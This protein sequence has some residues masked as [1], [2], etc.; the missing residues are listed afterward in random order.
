M[1]LPPQA[2]FHFIVLRLVLLAI[3]LL[4]GISESYGSIIL[5]SEKGRLFIYWGWNR[6]WYSKSNIGFLGDDYNFNLKRV[7]AKDRQSPF[8]FN[9]YL[10]PA[11]I[12][13]PQ[14]NFRIGYFLNDRWAVSV[15]MDHMKYVMVNDQTVKISGTIEGH[16]Y[17]G[18]YQNEDIV[19]TPDFLLFE[20]TDGLNY[21]NIGLSRFDQLLDLNKVKISL[22][23]GVG[24]GLLV[25]R[26]NAT[27]FG[28]ERYDEFHVSGFGF[29]LNVGLNATF[30]KYFFIQSELK[31]GFIDMPDI[32]TTKFEADK[33]KQSFYFLQSNIVFGVKVRVVREKGKSKDL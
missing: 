27:L 30:F 8:S 29:D 33:A 15:G 18:A 11:T 12:S 16:N 17:D 2:N 14:Y 19:L 6:G 25:P 20:H 3:L 32:R 24:I 28:E 4:P 26:T 5:G 10:N 13:I 23:E 22:I 31:G 1:W 7:V 21:A 9:K